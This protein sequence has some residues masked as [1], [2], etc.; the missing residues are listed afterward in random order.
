MNS[1]KLIRAALGNVAALGELYD[2]RT[3]NFLNLSIFNKKIPEEAINLTDN[4]FSDIHLIHSDSYSEKFSKLD[5]K[6][7]LQV[8]VLAGLFNPEG[9]GRY[10]SD[11]KTSAKAI[12][13]SLLYNIKTMDE[14]L[15]IYHQ[16]LKNI[17]ALEAIETGLATHVVIGISWGANSILSCEYLNT[18][19]RDVTE[20]EGSLSA[21]LK[22]IGSLISGKV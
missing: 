9:S 3:D 18:E 10:L 6:G 2:A 19:S 22:K 5:V 15:N 12:K 14:V 20:V 8:S 21:Q 17:F 16:D 13:S 1:S 11:I 4:H 7:E